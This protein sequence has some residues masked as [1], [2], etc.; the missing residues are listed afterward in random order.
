MGGGV[1][2]SVCLSVCPSVC[3]VPQHN[4]RMERPRKPKFG[5]GTQTEHEDPHQQQVL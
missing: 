3:S 4:S 1:C 2:L 5:F